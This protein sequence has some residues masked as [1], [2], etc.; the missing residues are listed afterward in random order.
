MNFLTTTASRSLVA[1][2][3]MMTPTFSQM[4]NL[5]DTRLLSSMKTQLPFQIALNLNPISDAKRT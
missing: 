1:M 5:S 3:H 2:A 4:L